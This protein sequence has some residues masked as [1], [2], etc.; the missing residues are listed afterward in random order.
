MFEALRDIK[1]FIESNN[2]LSHAIIKKGEIVLLLNEDDIYSEYYLYL[3]FGLH[4]DI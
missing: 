2:N 1:T 4:V 3:N